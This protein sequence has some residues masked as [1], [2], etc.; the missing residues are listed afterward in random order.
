MTLVLTKMAVGIPF[1]PLPIL[2][3]PSESRGKSSILLLYLPFGGFSSSSP[4]QS[5]AQLLE[6]FQATAVKKAIVVC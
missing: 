5:C 3:E 2:Q 6:G 4:L 1:L